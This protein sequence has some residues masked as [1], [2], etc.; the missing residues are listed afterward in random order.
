M[1]HYVVFVPS[2]PEAS[3]YEK[4]LQDAVEHWIRRWVG[5]SKPFYP[6]DGLK[7]AFA[8]N[9]EEVFAEDDGDDSILGFVEGAK[10][11]AKPCDYLARL[12]RD[13]ST[14]TR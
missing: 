4:L 6:I 1:A 5:N 13:T 14:L 8:I 10:T 9:L 11:I 7:G 12:E 2:Y 3:K